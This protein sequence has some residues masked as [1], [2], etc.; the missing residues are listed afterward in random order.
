MQ[1]K[2]LTEQQLQELIRDTVNET[3]DQYFGDPD[4]GKEVKEA[5]KQ[6]LLEIQRKRSTGRATIPAEEVY[7]RYGI[8]NNELFS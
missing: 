8:A 4:Q 3:L 6:N 1:I 7:K 2:D 5:F